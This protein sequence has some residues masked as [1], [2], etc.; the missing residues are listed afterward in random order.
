MRLTEYRSLKTKY[1]VYT[2]TATAA[3][4]SPATPTRVLILGA[5]MAGLAA[6]CAL[7][8]AGY[9]VRVLEARDVPG[10]RVQTLREGFT[11]GVYAEAGATY[12][13]IG[14]TLTIEYAQSLNLDLIDFLGVALPSLYFVKGR[15][16][17]DSA[18]ASIDWPY[19]LTPAERAMGLQGMQ[20]AYALPQLQPEQPIPSF[21]DHDG[22]TF[23]EYM[24]SRGASAGA[25]KLLN[26]GFNQLIGEGP[27]SYSAALMLADEAYTER[28]PIAKQVKGGND[29]FPKA[30]AARLGERI[31]YGAQVVA[32]DHPLGAVNVTYIESGARR[33]EHADYLICTLPYSVLRNI[34][35]TPPFSDAKQNAIRQLEYTPVTR[36]YLQMTGQFWEGQGISGQVQTDDP[37][38]SIYPGFQTAGPGMLEAYT[39]GSQA[40][41][42]AALSP[43]GR[44]EFVLGYLVK[45]YPE[46][47]RYYNGNGVSKDWDADP[48]SKGAYSW[49]RPGQMSALLGPVQM[50]EGRVYFAGD[51][52][53]NLPGWIEGA[54]QSALATAQAL[55]GQASGGSDLIW[56]AAS[57]G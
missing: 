11:E 54:L 36:V 9:E 40:R 42:L 15:L 3:V 23:S 24:L 27:D 21:L 13:P 43:G 45:Y 26:V 46:V 17:K 8:D 44:L 18:K 33:Q 51:H 32:I 52:C 30:L 7:S 4:P 19:D 16:I 22:M 50:P 20:K 29:L 53:S 41:A 2:L 47:R 35:V 38:T 37:V 39:A 28:H 48:W 5:G 34:P 14:H 25:V 56:K 55:G 6:G 10:G 49:F 12:L 31:V 1:N 57:K